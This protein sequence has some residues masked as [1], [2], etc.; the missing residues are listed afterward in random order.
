VSLVKMGCL[1]VVVCL[2]IIQCLSVLDDYLLF[3]CWA[4]I[5]ATAKW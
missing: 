2:S 3:R 4:L 1:I 5:Q